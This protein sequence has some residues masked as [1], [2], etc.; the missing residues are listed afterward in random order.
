[1]IGLELEVNDDVLIGQDFFVKATVTNKS[2]SARSVD[3]DVC[4]IAMM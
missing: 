4:T 2:S 3:V 1:M